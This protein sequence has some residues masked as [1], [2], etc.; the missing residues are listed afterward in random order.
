MVNGDDG[1]I[2]LC[3]N[4]ILSYLLW[5]CSMI[6]ENQSVCMCVCG[7]YWHLEGGIVD[8]RLYCRIM[9]GLIRSSVAV[10]F[11]LTISLCLFPLFSL[12]CRLPF[13]SVCVFFF[14][15]YTWGIHRVCACRICV[16]V[17]LHISYAWAWVRRGWNRIRDRE[18]EREWS[19]CMQLSTAK[20]IVHQ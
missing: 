14:F 2:W 5:R 10:N 16:V 13:Y 8:M 17:I 1:D 20:N 18:R 19:L 15:F 11:S 9:C 6:I 7:L 3:A 12:S 4:A